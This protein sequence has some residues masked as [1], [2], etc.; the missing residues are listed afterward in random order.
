MRAIEIILRVLITPIYLISVIG[1]VFY[2]GAGAII[3]LCEDWINKQQNRR[4][5]G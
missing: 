2:L 1:A 5:Y 4:E 3:I